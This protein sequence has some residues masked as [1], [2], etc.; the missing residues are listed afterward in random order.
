[1]ATTSIIIDSTSSGGTKIRKAITDINPDATNEQ[2]KSF[3]QQFNALSTNTYGATSRVKKTACLTAAEMKQLDVTLYT[4]SKSSGALSHMWIASG[5]SVP[6]NS[7]QMNP[8]TNE[9]YR[10]GFSLPMDYTGTPT[11]VTVPEGDAVDLQKSN[12]NTEN[13]WPFVIAAPSDNE[14]CLG[15]IV[16]SFPEDEN[17]AAAEFR[18]TVVAAVEEEGE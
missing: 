14:N 3:A 4:H 15:E 7:K 10:N 2:L 17:Y 1:M 16:V 5:S 12:K 6:I 18:C 13:F 8:G 9:N 11:V